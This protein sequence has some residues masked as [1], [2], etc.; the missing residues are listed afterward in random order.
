[1]LKTEAI[2]FWDQFSSKE[3]NFENEVRR[4]I[5]FESDGFN[6]LPEPPEGYHWEL[7]N[8]GLHIGN[9]ITYR[10]WSNK[11]GYMPGSE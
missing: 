11:I 8:G 5:W 6:P 3:P 10:L 9:S 7:D 1:M 2:N 4:G